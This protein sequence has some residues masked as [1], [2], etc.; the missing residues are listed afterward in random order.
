[1]SEKVNFKYKDFLIENVLKFKSD[2]SEEEVVAQLNLIQRKKIDKPVIAI[3]INSSSI[4]L[5][6][7]KLKTDIEE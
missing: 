4:I 3:S 6:A 2:K 5:G 7:Q 1:M